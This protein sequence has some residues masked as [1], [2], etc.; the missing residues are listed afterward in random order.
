SRVWQVMF[1]LPRTRDADG[2][3]SYQPYRD[4]LCKTK[5]GTACDVPYEHR[6]IAVRRLYMERVI[7]AVADFR[8]QYE[9]RGFEPILEYFTADLEK[10]KNAAV[11]PEEYP[12]LASTKSPVWTSPYTV[13][14]IGPKGAVI[15]SDNPDDRNKRTTEELLP[16]RTDWNLNAETGNAL[17]DKLG[18][19]L[20]AMRDAGAGA[21]YTTQVYVHADKS[22][23][24]R[25][26]KYL[27]RAYGP[28][29]M[30]LIDFVARR[31]FDGTRRLRRVPANTMDAEAIWPV[32]VPHPGGVWGC[33]P[34]A[35]LADSNVI[36][37]MIQHYVF[38]SKAGIVAGAAGKSELKVALD[39]DLAALG[40]WVTDTDKPTMIAVHGD[41]T[42]EQMH[43]VLSAVAF[44]CADK[45]CEKPDL[46]SKLA[47][48]ICETGAPP[49]KPVETKK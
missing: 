5:L 13:L 32:A 11:I 45:A 42:N 48:G 14:N 3:E 40:K 17:G 7:T 33:T 30:K 16:A 38:A 35:S 27:T 15:E 39:G 37:D 1:E 31:R 25:V 23:P 6:D 26:F 41:L 49:S 4:R 19:S 24:V 43:K 47:L 8:K 28:A 21:D 29:N 22:V 9:G 2:P 18:E 10:E 46:V 20:V 44:R 12:V 34:V 36:P